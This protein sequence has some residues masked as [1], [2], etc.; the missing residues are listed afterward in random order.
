MA[1]K[2]KRTVFARQGSVAGDLPVLPTLASQMKVD[3]LVNEKSDIWLLYDTAFREVVRYAEYDLDDN[4]VVLVT[5]TGKQQELGLVIP[6]PVRD[7][8]R[9]GAWMYLVQMKGKDIADFG[10]IPFIVRDVTLH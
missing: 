7:E 9:R 10:L 5:V 4:R 8:L 1:V 6:D 2:E 3:I